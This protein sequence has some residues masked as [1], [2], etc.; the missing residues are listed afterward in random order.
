MDGGFAHLGDKYEPLNPDD[1]ANIKQLFENRI[2]KGLVLFGAE[3][4]AFN[5]ELNPSGCI[6]NF[7]KRGASHDSSAHDT[8]GQSDMGKFAG[9]GGE[10]I[11]N[12]CTGGIHRKGVSRIGLYSQFSELFQ[13][14]SSEKLLFV[15]FCHISLCIAERLGG[16]DNAL[17]AK[18]KQLL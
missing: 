1:I 14:V 6:L 5:I 4:I 18:M 9:F 7:G 8:T 3:F 11:E 12:F 10:A 13:G 17:A 16:K 15:K 2:I